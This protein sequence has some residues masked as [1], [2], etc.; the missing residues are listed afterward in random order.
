MTMLSGTRPMHVFQIRYGPAVD[1]DPG[2][3]VLDN[4]ANE[5]P[6]WFEY[7]PI[8]R[9]LLGETLDEDAFYGFLS[10]RFKQKTNLTA[11]TV[12]ECIAAAGAATEVI[13]FGPSIHNSAY[14]LSV[15]EHGEAEH[16]GLCEVAAR[17]LERI[18]KP[19]DLRSLISDSR[20][21]VHSNYFVAKPRFW[22]A[23]L[24]V[25]EAI[26]ALAESADDPLGAALR[27]PTSYRGSRDTQ[28]KIF[29]VERIATLILVSDP[30]FATQVRDPF[31]ARARFYK[32]PVA[33]VCDA[34]KI[35]YVT[36]GRG[37]YMEVFRLVQGLRGFLNLQVRV[38]DRLGCRRVRPYL[39]NLKA[40]WHG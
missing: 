2:F 25:T 1:L 32:L 30:S 22:R 29:I 38:G 23:W 6:E 33:I 8:R 26:F 15:F 10:P 19:A 5:R 17:V 20:N 28:M 31:A 21:T 40:Y 24:A 12:H 36:Q 11:A 4:S 13:L 39:R 18:G 27:A 35:A 7:W 37:Q 9:F 16:P 14:Y 3:E 34:L